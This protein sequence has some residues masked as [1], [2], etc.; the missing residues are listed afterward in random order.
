MADGLTDSIKVEVME[1]KWRNAM[2][3]NAWTEL[4]GIEGKRMSASGKK[5]VTP[6][7]SSNYL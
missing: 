1:R 3:E 4:E 7:N 6:A 5:W 2:E